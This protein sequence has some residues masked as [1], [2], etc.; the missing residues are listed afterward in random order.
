MTPAQEF[1]DL[2]VISQ[3]LG[4]VAWAA[5]TAACLVTAL[6]DRWM[7]QTVWPVVLVPHLVLAV[8]W[9]TLNVRRW[10][11]DAYSTAE[12]REDVAPLVPALFVVWT[13]TMLALAVRLRTAGRMAN[14][15]ETI[16]PPRPTTDS[17]R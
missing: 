8:W 13:A 12:F 6:R 14:V 2:L 17:A 7:R 4:S 5:A 15:I 1:T 3:T 10:L 11:S 16:T 9:S